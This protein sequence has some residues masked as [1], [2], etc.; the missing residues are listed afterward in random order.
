MD[1]SCE[2]MEEM[3]VDYVDGQLSPTESNQVAEHLEK[4]EP[5]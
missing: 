3:L 5:C 1:K 2:M 4:C